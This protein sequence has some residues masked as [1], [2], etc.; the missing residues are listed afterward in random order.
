MPWPVLAHFC[1]KK[2]TNEISLIQKQEHSI[3]AISI[4]VLRNHIQLTSVVQAVLEK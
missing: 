3:S 1:T 4:H 2:N